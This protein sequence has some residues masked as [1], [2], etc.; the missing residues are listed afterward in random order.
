MPYK[1][2][3]KKAIKMAQAAGFDI[4]RYIGQW[5]GYDVY[6]PRFNDD[7]PRYLGYPQYILATGLNLRWTSDNN[8]SIAVMKSLK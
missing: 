4:A 7:I 5:H 3:T 6:E 2:T 1:T 8:E